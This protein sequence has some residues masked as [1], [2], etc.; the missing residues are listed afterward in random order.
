MNIESVKTL[1]ELFSGEEASEKYI[2]LI[3]LS[4]I[5][6]E[7]MLLPDVDHSDMRLDF[8]CAAFA[9]HKL[10]EVNAARE[11]S[12]YTSAGKMLTVSQN[13][14]LK[15][16]KNLLHDYMNLCAELI[17]EKTFVFMGFSDITEE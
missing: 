11:R 17:K 5:E 16:A 14:A 3:T 12:E 10:Q 7:R 1:F 13:T 4:V 15:Y 6:V 9:N 2:P 8:L